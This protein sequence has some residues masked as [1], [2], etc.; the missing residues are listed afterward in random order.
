MNRFDADTWREAARQLRE[1]AA[2]R[3]E[4]DCGAMSCV[5]ARGALESMARRFDNEAKAAEGA[6]GKTDA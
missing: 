2:T 1:E 4:A 6:R 5:G 3:C